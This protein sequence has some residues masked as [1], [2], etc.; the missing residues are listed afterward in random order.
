LLAA[1]FFLLLLSGFFSG[2]ET[3]LTAAS[4]ARMLSLEKEGNKRAAIVDK[5]LERK[6]RMIGALL[7]G[8]T[9]VNILASALATSAFLQIS[10]ET[11]VVYAT[12]LMT[13]LILIFSEVLPK[14]YALHYA[15]SMSMAVAPLVRVLI[16]VL[17]P[18]VEL[19]TQIVR[20]TLR[21]FG[22]D[23]TVAGLGDHMEVLRGVIEQHRGPEEETDKQR[24]MLRSVLDLVDVEVGAVM[25]HRRNVETIDVGQPIGKIV[26]EV[27]KSPFTRIPIWK[28]DPE[29]IIGVIHAKL[30]LK[31]LQA[32]AGSFKSVSI[33]TIASEPWFVPEK[34]TLSDQLQAFRKRREHFALVVDEYGSLMGVVTLEDILEEIVGEID[35]EM[36]EI[37]TGVRKQPNGSY[38]VEGT[39]TIRDLNRD[40]EW[41]LPDGK[42]YSTVAGLILHES[43]MIPDVGRIF[44][45]FNFTF[46]VLRRQRNQITL[47]RIIPPPKTEKQGEA[48]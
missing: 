43:Q 18:V 25:T 19:V 45:F 20:L 34:T 2:S 1:I 36:D 21:I 13:V 42:G 28:D 30:L 39:V 7:L 16:A 33:E 29:N 8:N 10:G 41:D 31:E 22:V 27:L 6:E 17:A 11:G 12:A 47:V 5:I 38:V 24:A 26:E 32:A 44:H 46:E 14:T 9:L 40:F 23:I 4:K 48:A 35:D 3:A 15:D 37:A